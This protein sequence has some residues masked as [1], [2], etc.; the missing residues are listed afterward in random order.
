MALP[1]YPWY[2]SDP[3]TDPEGVGPGVKNCRR[4]TTWGAPW[5]GIRCGSDGLLL[6]LLL[7]LLPLTGGASPGP[8]LPLPPPPPYTLLVSADGILLRLALKPGGGGGGSMRLPCG[9]GVLPL[10]CGPREE[11][12]AVA[13][14]AV[15]LL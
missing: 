5:G 3:G 6:L 1:L 7:L 8:A 11:K 4:G 10:L 13:G 12:T 14:P 2:P 9:P 15:P